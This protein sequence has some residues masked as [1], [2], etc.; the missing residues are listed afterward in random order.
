V[1]CPSC[2]TENPADQSTCSQCDESLTETASSHDY[3][4][5]SIMLWIAIVVVLAGGGWITFSS[6]PGRHDAVASPDPY[7]SSVAPSTPTAPSTEVPEDES[8]QAT[9]MNTLLGQIQSTHSELPDSIGSCDAVSSN[10]DALK[11]IVSERHDQADAAS[12]L[13]TDQLTD[14]TELGSALVEMAQS[15]LDA[16]QAYLDWAQNAQSSGACTG[17]EQND[18]IRTA[19]QRAANAKRDFAN[20][21]NGYAPQLGQ[22]TYSWKTF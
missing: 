9:A 10:V 15:N 19:N 11:Q 12:G 3:V 5:N 1:K 6:W 18:T 17:S 2:D 4:V 16:D 7:P 22:P 21:W 14:G 8:T 13:H 20:L